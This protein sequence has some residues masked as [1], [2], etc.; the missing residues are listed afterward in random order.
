[1][2]ISRKGDQQECKKVMQPAKDENDGILFL[3]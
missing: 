3:K 2:L 1:L